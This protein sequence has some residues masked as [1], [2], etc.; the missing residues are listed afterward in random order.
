MTAVEPP[1]K[2]VPSKG[3]FYRLCRM[4]HGWL[5]ALS[6]LALLFFSVTG[7]LLNHPGWLYGNPSPAQEKRFALTPHDVERLR[8]SSA[9]AQMLAGL[10][11]ERTGAVGAYSDGDLVGNDVF[12]RMRGVRGTSEVRANLTDGTVEVLMAQAHPVSIFN[13]LHRGEHA[14]PVWRLLIDVAAGLL[15]LTSVIGYA[16]FL[17]LRFRLRTG[18]ILTV[19]SLIVCGGVFVLA[20]S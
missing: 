3:E 1:S 9:P 6:F 8:Q 13:A 5:S 15:V 10:A 20:T 4:V 19:L 2:L 12:V 16:I 18:L 7:I 17:S 14:G 11:V